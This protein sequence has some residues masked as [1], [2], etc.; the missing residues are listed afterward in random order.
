RI[1]CAEV[2]ASLDNESRHGT[3]HDTRS[4]LV[5]GRVEHKV[6]A[7][8]DVFEEVRDRDRLLRPEKLDVDIPQD[9]RE[10]DCVAHIRIGE[11]SRQIDRT[12]A[13]GVLRK[14]R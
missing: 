2:A 10:A 5:R 4:G 6:P 11:W 7:L 3:M 1:Y 12:R 14:I 8:I 13:A 9:G